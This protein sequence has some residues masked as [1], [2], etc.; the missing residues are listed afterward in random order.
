MLIIKKYFL[1][2]LQVYKTVGIIT[3]AA[4]DKDYPRVIRYW[5]CLHVDISKSKGLY[6]MVRH[7]KLHTF[8]SS[9][10]HSSQY[11]E[12]ITKGEDP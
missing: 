4:A 12:I 9:L 5:S 7:V 11:F 3:Q 1:I 2:P 8:A 6:F 10:V